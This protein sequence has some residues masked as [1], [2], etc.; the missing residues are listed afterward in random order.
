[1]FWQSFI[2]L[3]VCVLG[4]LHMYICVGVLWV[5]IYVW[6]GDVYTYVCAYVNEWMVC[7]HMCERVCTWVC[8]C[9]ECVHK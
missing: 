9:V 1:M 4:A 7:M 2:H 3:C 8:A 5:C 6:M